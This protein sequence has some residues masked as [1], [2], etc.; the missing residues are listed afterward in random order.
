MMI[1]LIKSIVP[2]NI[3][4]YINNYKKDQLKKRIEKLPKL[5]KNELADIIS[6]KLKLSN[7]DISFVHSSLDRLNLDFPSFQVL[8]ILLELVGDEG[9]LIFPTYPKL[10]SYK[11]LKSGEVFNIN[12]TPS[13]MGILSEFA[14]RHSKAIRSL[15]P[16]KSVVAIGKNAEE[17]T[18]S[19]HL[20]IYPYD[21]NSPYY[22]AYTL[23]SKAIGIGVKTTFFSAVHILDDLYLDNLPINPYK[24]ELFAAK[25]LDKKK[26]EIIVNTYAHDMDKMH[27]DLPKFF[28]SKIDKTIC[29]D[30]NIDGMNFF[31]SD[32]YKT[33]DEM[34]NLLKNG[35]SIYKY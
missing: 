7:G 23:G 34:R 13:Y 11:Y 25:C 27:F 22:K 17:I 3:K 35:I 32:L 24:N 26:E 18:S 29:E 21:K 10:T 16:T 1:E 9:T 12:R 5:S 4:K 20:S 33:I 6:N 14:R 15:H 31:T 8:D 28:N 2:D 19:H 30:I